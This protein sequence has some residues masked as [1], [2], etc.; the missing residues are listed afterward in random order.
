MNLLI[1]KRLKYFI[2][3]ME[4]KCLNEAA[5]QL[6]I[7][8]SPLGRV[9]YEMEGHIGDKLFNRS[10]NN[11]EPTSLA[12]ALYNKVKPHY[13]ALCTAEREFIIGFDKNT[14]ELTFDISIPDIIFQFLSKRFVNLKY[15]VSCRQAS[16][17]A[18]E[19]LTLSTKPNTAILTLRKIQ[20][21]DSFHTYSLGE[22]T[23]I[24][25]MPQN[26]SEENFNHIESAANL[27]LYIKNDKYFHE[28]KGFLSHYIKDIFPYLNIKETGDDLSVQLLSVSSGDAILLLPEN[29]SK[30]FNPPETKIV[31]LL[32]KNI[33]T[34]LY[35]NK[36]FRDTKLIRE[37]ISEMKH[38]Q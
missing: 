3:A 10:Y 24:A 15:P 12:Y 35:I 14:L 22:E 23:L 27:T 2:T 38:Y 21:N 33:T 5:D 29:L 28:K 31:K 13:D 20:Q 34:L 30:Y 4:T 19:I 6:C 9:L 7:T 8:R 26:I 16:V 25:L 37:I 18:S 11:L 32:N 36:K 1:S 17:S